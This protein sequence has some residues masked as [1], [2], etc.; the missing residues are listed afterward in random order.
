MS[1]EELDIAILAK[2]SCG[3]HLSQL[4]CRSKQKEQTVRSSQRTDFFHHGLKIC[5]QTFKYM[6]TVGQDKLNALIK[7]YKLHGVTPRTH[8]NLKRQPPNALQKEDNIYV[9]NSSMSQVSGEATLS[10]SPQIAP[11]WRCMVITALLLLQS[12]GEWFPWSLFVASGGKLC[13]S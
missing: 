4:T 1:R 9:A 13:H 10:S 8:G 2:L 6:H 5:R 11:K 7:H 3:M 12:T